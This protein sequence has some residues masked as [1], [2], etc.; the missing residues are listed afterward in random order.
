MDD[1]VGSQDGAGPSGDAVTPAVCGLR[2]DVSCSTESIYR[3]DVVASWWSPLS[4]LTARNRA[5]RLAKL[6]E[7][8]RMSARRYAPTTFCSFVASASAVAAS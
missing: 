2:F 3:H 8:R 1:D 5:P 7:S 6:P 4:G